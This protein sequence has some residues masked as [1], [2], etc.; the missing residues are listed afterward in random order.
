M[1]ALRRFRLR[2]LVFTRFELL[3]SESF[4]EYDEVGINF[5]TFF[6]EMVPLTAPEV[7]LKEEAA[8]IEK[9]R[10]FWFDKRKV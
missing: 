9:C 8:A 1:E 2:L 7:E 4:G 6:V 5:F 3:K 10:D